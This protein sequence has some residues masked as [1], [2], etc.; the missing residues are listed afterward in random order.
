MFI[1][2]SIKPDFFREGV[3]KAHSMGVN[4]INVEEGLQKLMNEK[5]D[6]KEFSL[7]LGVLCHYISD[8]FCIYHNEKGKGKKRPEHIKYEVKLHF[9]LLK[10]LYSR[11]LHTSIKTISHGTDILSI[12]PDMHK[13][14]LQE[15][16][17][18]YKD[19][20]YSLSAAMH[21]TEAVICYAL[22]ENNAVAKTL[23]T[24]KYT[25]IPKVIPIKKGIFP[26]H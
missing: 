3:P 11:K 21:I 24:Y 6:V 17:S 18:E 2:G 16:D 10:L 13:N 1:Y 14:Y 12:I 20:A 8:F 15:A 7:T 19:L 5:L 26:L 9:K 22:L 25:G 4:L 23:K